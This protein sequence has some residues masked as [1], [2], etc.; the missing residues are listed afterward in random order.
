MKTRVED[1]GSGTKTDNEEE[2]DE[3][4]REPREKSRE[5]E[6]DKFSQPKGR[7]LPFF[8]C[9]YTDTGGPHCRG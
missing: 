1:T 2:C 3:R 8:H 9:C 4:D 7:T 5:R 6:T